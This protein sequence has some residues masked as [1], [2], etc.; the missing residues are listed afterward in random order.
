K[1]FNRIFAAWIFEDDLPFTTGESSGLARLFQ[2][3][4][5]HFLLPSDTTVRNALAK[6]F[7]DLHGTVVRELAIAYST[8]T[9][10]TRQM[11]F[12]FAG[13]LAHFID[14]D[15]NLVETLIDFYHLQDDDHKG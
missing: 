13:T 15:W 6:I 10:T 2:Y 9:W 12:T 4:K 7:I 8:D 14:D 3:L 5:V 11:V 1:G